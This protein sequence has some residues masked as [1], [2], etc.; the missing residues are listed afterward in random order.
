M[1]RAVS[2][3]LLL[4]SAG[5]ALAAEPPET[6]KRTNFGVRLVSPT[7]A[8]VDPSLPPTEITPALEMRE[9]ADLGARFGIVT[10]THRSVAHNR[11]VGGVPNSYHLRNRAI[12]IARRPGVTHRQIDAAYRA[13]GYRLIESLDEGD[14]SHFAFA[15]PNPVAVIPATQMVPT[16]PKPT[17]FRIVTMPQSTR[18]TAN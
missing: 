7:K 13:A 4:L 15:D 6:S 5:V 9:V 1:L 10:S 3:T 8:Y 16:G 2:G 18:S 11:Q 12:D 17:D 14:H